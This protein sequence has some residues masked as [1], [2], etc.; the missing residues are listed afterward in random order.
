MLLGL[1]HV[2]DFERAERLRGVFD[3]LDLESDR[4]QRLDDGVEVGVGVEVIFEP[5]EGE[6]HLFASS[7]KETRF[8]LPAATLSQR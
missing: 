2:S 4:G 1:D 5:G 8:D 3:L 7:S 6:F